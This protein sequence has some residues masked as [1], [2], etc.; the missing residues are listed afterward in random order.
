MSFITIY[1]YTHN[2]EST[3]MQ[4]YMIVHKYIAITQ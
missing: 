4:T 2:E 3:H 1:V